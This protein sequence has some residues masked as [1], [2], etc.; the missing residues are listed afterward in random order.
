MNLNKILALSSKTEAFNLF[1]T[2]PVPEGVTKLSH[3]HVQKFFEEN[4]G[5][6]HI[7]IPE[8]VTHIGDYAFKKCSGLENVDFPASLT[9]IDNSA[10]EGCDNLKRV[11]FP[12]LLEY[13]GESAFEG[14]DNLKS[15]NFPATSGS[16]ELYIGKSTFSRCSALETVSFPGSV[17]IIN[18]GDSAFYGC[19]GL[20]KV[21][22]PDSLEYIGNDVFAFCYNLKSVDFSDTLWHIG[23]RAFNGCTGLKSANFPASLTD[24]DNSAFKGCSDLLILA[25]PGL[26]GHPALKSIPNSQL[27]NRFALFSIPLYRKGLGKEI[28]GFV[29]TVLLVAVRPDFLKTQEADNTNQKANDLPRMPKEIWMHI[30]GCLRLDEMRGG[31]NEA[32]K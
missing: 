19:I 31:A 4:P 20:K 29:T 1:K 24:I 10:F 14:C 18:I 9:D 26:V 28:I 2:I 8:G 12:K 3:A 6:T 25:P 17:V 22:F 11:D 30:L 13:I 23:A 27:F 21:S 15:A 7:K 5:V 32:P 16:I